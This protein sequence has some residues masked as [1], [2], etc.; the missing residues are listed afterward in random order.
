MLIFVCFYV[1]EYGDT[2]EFWFNQTSNEMF[3]PG[4]ANTHTGQVIF[5]NER[6]TDLKEMEEKNN[7]VT[8]C[9]QIIV[10]LL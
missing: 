9:V 4:K 8:T 10:L 1:A 6:E 3:K 2:L 5:E 7:T